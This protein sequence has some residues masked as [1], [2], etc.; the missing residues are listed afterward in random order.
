AAHFKDPGGAIR[1]VD[2]A[3]GWNWAAVVDS[4]Q[5]PAMVAK[6]RDLHPRSEPQ[7]AMGGGEFVHVVRLATRSRPTFKI[8]SIPRS[9]PDV[10]GLGALHARWFVYFRALT[11]LSV[12]SNLMIRSSRRRRSHRAGDKCSDGDGVEH[13]FVYAFHLKLPNQFSPIRPQ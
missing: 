5:N 7:R 3:I 6:V 2:D 4:D 1:E 12:W 9:G 8:G 13:D 11:R 10:E